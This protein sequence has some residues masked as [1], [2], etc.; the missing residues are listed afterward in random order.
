MNEQW[1]RWEPLPELMVNYSLEHVHNGMRGLEILLA[2]PNSVDKKVRVLFAYTMISYTIGNLS[3]EPIDINNTNEA[4]FCNSWAF[5][6]VAH[7]KY[8]SHLMEQS[9]TIV[10]IYD[11][12]HFVILATNARIDIVASYEPDVT[13]I[14]MD[15]ATK[16]LLYKEMTIPYVVRN[17]STARIILYE[18]ESKNNTQT[19]QLNLA[20]DCSAPL[21]T[22]LLKA[23][24][25]DL[26][27]SDVPLPCII[28]DL[29]TL[30][31]HEKR[32]ILNKGIVWRQ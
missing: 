3:D 16:T 12:R 9:A 10:E 23:V 25:K 5:F 20:L 30:T 6:E 11:P 1:K 13:Y 18:P 19:Q 29:C 17:L 4:P 24:E 28:L 14:I 27:D 7:S 26:K 15:L 21:D 22:V 8:I 31:D 32:E 2:D